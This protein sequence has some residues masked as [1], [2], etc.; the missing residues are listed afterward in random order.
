MA[1]WAKALATGTLLSPALQQERLAPTRLP[2]GTVTSYGLGITEVLPPCASRVAVRPRFIGHNGAV[3]GFQSLVGYAPEV[4]GTIVV[5]T[6]S[7]I[8]PNTP[9]AQAFPADNLAKIIQ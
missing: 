2:D 9:L 8:A 7:E 1:I 3:P 4:E 5:L 6:N